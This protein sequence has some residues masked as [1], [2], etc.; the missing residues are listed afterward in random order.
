MKIALVFPPY[1]HKEFSEN[2]SV[3]DDEF[4]KYPP[5]NLAYVAA[6]LEKSGHEVILIDSNALG[7]SKHETLKMVREFGPDFMGFMLTTYM[8]RE[9]C[10]W[11]EY[12][13]KNT[14]VPV[15]VGGINV[16]NYPEE[17]IEKDYIDYAIIGPSSESLPRFIDAVEKGRPLDRIRGIAYMKGGKKIV[18]QPVSF[19]ENID[20]LPFPARHLLPNSRYYSFI[21]KRKNFTIMLLSKGCPYKCTFCAITNI[22]YYQRGIDSVMVEIKECYYR[23][24]IREIDFF[25]ACFTVN[26]EYVI[27]LCKFIMDS[28]M[29]FDW[30]CRTRVDLVDDE[31]LHYMSRAG[32]KRIYYGI[33]SASENI[34]SIMNKGINLKKI[35]ESIRLTKKH[36]IKALG[37]FMLGNPGETIESMNATIKLSKELDLDYVQ[38]MHT[39]P[40]PMTVLDNEMKSG[41]H[42]YWR[43]YVAGRADERRIETDWCDLPENLIDRYIRMAYISFYLRPS[44]IL[45]TMLEIKSFHELKRYIKS[46]AKMMLWGRRF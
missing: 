7:L 24:G 15:F 19:D 30:S 44:Y 39:I 27:K 29:D 28:D 6:I 18:N 42:D 31:L 45:K 37:F 22:P 11:I 3:V 4:G 13:K 5:L 21:S 46:A 36:G 8:F 35:K 26:R 20:E 38:F 23:Y 1:H 9:T 17:T 12:L 2:L 14:G 41:N 10:S 34:L 40:K 33:E 25:D 16:W 43:E 32:C